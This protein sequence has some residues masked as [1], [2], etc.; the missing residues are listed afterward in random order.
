MRGLYLDDNTFK[1]KKLDTMNYI[2]APPIM[3]MLMAP[4]VV[5]FSKTCFKKLRAMTTNWPEVQVYIHAL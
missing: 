1:W 3:V 5:S 4:V 2:T